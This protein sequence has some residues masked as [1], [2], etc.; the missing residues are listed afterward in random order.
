MKQKKNWKKNPKWPTQKTWVYVGHPHNQIG[1]ATSMPFTSINPTNPRTNLWNCHK[2]N[3]RIGDFEKLS[4]FEWAIL[5]FFFPKIFFLLD[6][7]W[8]SVTNYNYVIE[9]MGL[10]YDVFQQIPCY[11]YCVI[12]RYIV[13]VQKTRGLCNSPLI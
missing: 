4:F 11:A 9:W 6:P 10:N 3:W 2:K 13:Y 1:W 5:E 7:P 8:K 12:L